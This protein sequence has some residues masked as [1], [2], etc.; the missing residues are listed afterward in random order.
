MRLQIFVPEASLSGHCL[1]Y[2]KH[3]GLYF[4]YDGFLSYDVECC[5][6]THCCRLFAMPRIDRC[7]WCFNKE[8]LEHPLVVNANIASPNA[9]SLALRPERDGG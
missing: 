8:R 1:T 3:N 5:S 2:L 7:I 4:P 6:F 9:Q